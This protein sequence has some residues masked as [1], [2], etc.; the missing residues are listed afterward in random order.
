MLGHEVAERSSCFFLQDIC[1]EVTGRYISIHGFLHFSAFPD[2]YGVFA[3]PVL[4]LQWFVRVQA[5]D[6]NHRGVLA[7]VTEATTSIHMFLEV[8]CPW[9][10][11]GGSLLLLEV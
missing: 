6:N 1:L 3:T 5:E 2:F 11:G 4:L 8:A 10:I 7:V 9:L